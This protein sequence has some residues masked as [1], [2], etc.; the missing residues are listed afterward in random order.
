MVAMNIQLAALA[1]SGGTP[2]PILQHHPELLIVF[3][4]GWFC[5]VVSVVMFVLS[6]ASGWAL[7]AKRFRVDGDFMGNIWN[8]QSGRLRSWCNYNNCLK[9][10]A[11]GQYLYLGVMKPFGFFH[12]PLLIPWSE[13]EVQTGKMI[14]GF[15]DTALLRLGREEQV[16]LRVYGR[17]VDRLRQAAGPGWPNYKAEQMVEEMKGGRTR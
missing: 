12:A 11:D 3:V 4:V 2:P 6:R 15:Y 10:G 8:W 9:V 13:I 5:L 16:S 17:L 7:L 1:I 14:F